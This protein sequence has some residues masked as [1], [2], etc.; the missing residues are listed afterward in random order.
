VTKRERELYLEYMRAH[1]ST[2]ASYALALARALAFAEGEV[3]RMGMDWTACTKCKTGV[4]L[5]LSD[6]GPEGASMIF[7]AW[8]CSNRNCRFGI[9]I[10]KGQVTYE[11]IPV[12]RK[13]Y[14]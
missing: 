6:Y 5:P 12:E 1:P 9:R 10:D 13:E 4:L 2:R 11:I 3:R 7:K 14:P 8:C